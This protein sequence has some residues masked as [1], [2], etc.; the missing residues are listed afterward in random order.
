MAPSQ[1]QV[2]QAAAAGAR[3]SQLTERSAAELS[4]VVSSSWWIVGYLVDIPSV[5][6]LPSG[7]AAAPTFRPLVGSDLPVFSTTLA[8]A[9]PASGGGT[10]NYLRADGSWDAPPGA[11][12][13]TV[14]QVVAATPLTGGTISST[15]TI[16]LGTVSS[17][18]TFTSLNAVIDVYGRVTKASNG[19]AGTV[20]SIVAASPLTGG[21]ITSTGTVAMGTVTSSGT[22]SSANITVDTYGRVTAAANGIGGGGGGLIAIQASAANRNV[23]GWTQH[24]LGVP[25]SPDARND[26]FDTNSAANWTQLGTPAVLQ[27]I[28]STVKSHAY[29][30]AAQQSA[31]NIQGIYKAYT[32]TAGDTITVFLTDLMQNGQFNMAG[33]CFCEA[34][35]VHVLA[36]GC[37]WDATGAMQPFQKQWTALSGGSTPSPN[38]VIYPSG[39][40]IYLRHVYT[41]STSVS[42]YWSKNGYIWNFINTANPG[43]TIGAVGLFVN[44]QK[45]SLGVAAFFDFIR[46]NWTP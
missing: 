36:V 25:G 14:T 13:G 17:S 9:V 18:G 33:L 5:S 15:G 1:S 38:I 34:T 21:T 29:L 3:G 26:E 10:T 22:F 8:G 31:Y 30:S 19:V 23:T 6:S 35:P 7:A 42:S 24:A 45:A 20:T 4:R 16:G 40:P 12:S 27:D 39:V 46:F 43:F 37:G 41:S 11:T 28:N 44:C 32:P 2:R